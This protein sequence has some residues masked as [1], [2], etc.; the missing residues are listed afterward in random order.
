[1]KSL[2]INILL[3]LGVTN[4]HN[5]IYVDMI[6]LNHIRNKTSEF[7]QIIFWKEYPTIGLDRSEFRAIGF[8]VI[9][10]N[11]HFPYIHNQNGYYKVQHKFEINGVA[12]PI[13]VISKL[14]RESWSMTDP[15]RESVRKHWNGDCPIFFKHND[16]PLE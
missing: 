11:D 4:S 7:D 3:L 9:S 8:Q 12:R 14:Y 13:S 1:M 2:L 16:D 6:E 5:E 15:E 10:G